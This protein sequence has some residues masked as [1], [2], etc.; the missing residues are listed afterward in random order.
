MDFAAPKI[1]MN[2]I[3][4]FAHL[5]QNAQNA[6]SFEM[7]FSCVEGHLPLNYKSILIRYRLVQFE[8]LLAKK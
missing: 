6:F 4:V 8:S 3:V 1:C 2:Q 7:S 5:G